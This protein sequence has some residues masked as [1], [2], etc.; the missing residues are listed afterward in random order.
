MHWEPLRAAGMGLGL[1]R[2]MS[3]GLALSTRHVALCTQCVLECLQSTWGQSRGPCGLAEPSTS[4][5]WPLLPSTEAE[6]IP[7][8]EPDAEEEG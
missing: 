4:H 2:A 5:P 8:G 3:R 1:L 6:I 7:Q